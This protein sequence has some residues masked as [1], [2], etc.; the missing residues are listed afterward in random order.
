MVIASLIALVVGCGIGFGIGH[1]TA[2]GTTNPASTKA[3]VAMVKVSGT[4]SLIDPSGY[5]TDGA[6]NNGDG[7]FGTGGYND[8]VQGAGVVVS[9]DAG[10][11]L[12][13]TAL[14]LGVIDDSGCTFPFSTKVPGGERF[15][16]VTVTHRGTI[17]E[18]ESE[19]GSIALTL[20][21]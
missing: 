13:L 17:K 4:M 2:D 9:D 20:G 6:G 11:T 12:A 3:A 14:G 21:D 16:G 15:Y 10:N 19:L 8:I 18:S 5:Y 7:C 1:A